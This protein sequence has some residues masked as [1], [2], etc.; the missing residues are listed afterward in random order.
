MYPTSIAEQLRARG[1]DVDAVTGRPELRGLPDDAVF[2]A[3]QD[4]HRAV[5]T[6][7]VRDFSALANAADQRG[8]AYHGLVL[9]DPAK[10]PRGNRRT[11]GHLVRRL[12]VLLTEHRGNDA[13]SSRHWL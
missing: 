8:H 9:V 11:I 12:D 6:E 7:N 3:A 2:A 13:M 1:H 10:Y 5:V 4:E